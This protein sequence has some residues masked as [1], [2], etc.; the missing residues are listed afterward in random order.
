MDLLMS[1]GA[2]ATRQGRPGERERIDR[3]NVV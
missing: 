3:L 1:N 2:L